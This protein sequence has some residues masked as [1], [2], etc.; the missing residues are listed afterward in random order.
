MMP[1]IRISLMTLEDLCGRCCGYHL[2]KVPSENE[3]QLIAMRA[4]GERKPT[5]K[6]LYSSQATN[7]AQDD[8]SVR[9]GTYLKQSDI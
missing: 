6:A 8:I 5:F 1:T 4:L 3:D 7:I 2:H 9:I